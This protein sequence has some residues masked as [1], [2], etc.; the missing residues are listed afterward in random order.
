M[1]K[2]VEEGV[3]WNNYR[4]IVMYNFDII[5]R[6][7]L[8]RFLIKGFAKLLTFYPL[9]ENQYNIFIK[10]S[11]NQKSG[12][13]SRYL[14]KICKSKGFSKSMIN[15][16]FRLKGIYNHNM[17][18]KLSDVERREMVKVYLL[19]NDYNKCLNLYMNDYDLKDSFDDF[20]KYT[21]MLINSLIDPFIKNIRKN[22]KLR[23]CID[24]PIENIDEHR[25]PICME[26]NRENETI[27]RLKIKKQKLV[28]SNI[29][30]DMK[31]LNKELPTIEDI[32]K[33][34]VD[35]EMKKILGGK[36]NKST[37]GHTKLDH[38]PTELYESTGDGGHDQSGPVGQ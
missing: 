31:F 9:N 36:V 21:L 15:E 19:L 27:R 10:L 17:N 30:D 4:T 34:R 13:L 29:S 20:S 26:R 23:K 1:F 25:R 8:P 14:I 33:E 32:I 38:I 12:F 7:N 28:L 18:R 35:I 16:F 37:K 24:D 6:I 5:G 2:K 11:S 3:V 22:T